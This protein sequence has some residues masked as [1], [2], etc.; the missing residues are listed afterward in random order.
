[1]EKFQTDMDTFPARA[2]YAPAKRQ[3]EIVCH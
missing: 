3:W 1:M 2:K